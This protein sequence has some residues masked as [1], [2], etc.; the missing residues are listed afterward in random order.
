MPVECSSRSR[1]RLSRRD[2]EKYDQPMEQ[3]VAGI[4]FG[5]VGVVYGTL[6]LIFPDWFLALSEKLP[7]QRF[8]R[9]NVTTMGIFF[10]G[11][12][13]VAFVALFVMPAVTGLS[14]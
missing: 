4:I 12:G 3:S 11:F 8:T 5:V 10:I 6:L 2:H 9:K 1:R 13:I 14:R 7:G